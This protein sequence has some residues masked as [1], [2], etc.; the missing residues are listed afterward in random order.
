MVLGLIGPRSNSSSRCIRSNLNS[1]NR[2]R[3]I[4]AVV[5]DEECVCNAL[6][7]LLQSASLD[8]ET[9]SSGLEFLQSLKTHQPDCVILDLHMPRINGFLIQARLA[10]ASVRL[11]VVVLTGHDDA[12]T[13]ELALAGGAFAFLHKP[14]DDQELLDAITTAIGTH[15]KPTMPTQS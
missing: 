14:V 2:I 9:F 8:V 10:E 6:R 15:L 11:P 5:D 4:I 13:R 3:P 1:V 7:W 12:K